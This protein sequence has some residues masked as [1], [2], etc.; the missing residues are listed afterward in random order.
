MDLRQLE[1]FLSVANHLHFRQAAE[2]LHL[3]PATVSESIRR[4]EAEIGTALFDRS[5]RHVTLTRSGENF[6]PEARRALRTIT[7]TFERAKAHATESTSLLIVGHSSEGVGRLVRA[8]AHMQRSS[9]GLAIEL[10]EA[11]SAIQLRKLTAGQIHAAVVCGPP[12][13][14]AFERARVASIDIRA[15]VPPDEPFASSRWLTTAELVRRPLL[16]WPRSLC[17]AAYDAVAGIFRAED[18]EWVPAGEPV[19]LATVACRV[20]AGEGVGIVFAPSPIRVTELGVRAVPIVDAPRVDQFIA[21]RSTAA[22]SELAQ[23]VGLLRGT[24]SAQ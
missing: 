5:T 21:W 3:S 24:D 19:G 6:Y 4:L 1:C 15:I 2:A 16:L 18:P 13:G 20:L 22:P 14:N 11:T 9:P 12:A 7:A 17:P 8:C 23:L 10:I